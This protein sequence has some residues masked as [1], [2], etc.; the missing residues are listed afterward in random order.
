MRL[1]SIIIRRRDIAEV[2]SVK[3][4]GGLDWVLLLLGAV[5]VGVGVVVVLSPILPAGR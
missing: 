1:G 4:E 5:V 2:R 3:V